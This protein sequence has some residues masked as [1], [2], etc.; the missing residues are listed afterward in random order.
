[1]K[2]RVSRIEVAE[3]AGVSTTT[4]SYVLNGR[5][6]MGIPEVTRDRVLRAASD[7]GY[8]PN[9]AA[10]SLRTGRS[11]L[12]ALW[13]SVLGPAYY[14]QIVSQV[15]E[16]LRAQ[17]YEM[18]VTDT[19]PHPD[20]QAHLDRLSQ[21]P[22]D[23]I[24]AFDSARYVDHYRA[25]HGSHT[26]IVAMGVDLPTGVDTV[27]LDLRCGAEAAMEHLC[28]HGRQRVA[29]VSDSIGIAGLEPRM[30]AYTES[31]RASH[32]DPE[33]II[34][35]RRTRRSAYEAM[36]AHIRAQGCPQAIFCYN[37]DLAMGVQRAV[38]DAGYRIP[39]DVAIVGHDGTEET[40]FTS[41][42]LSTVLLPTERMCATAWELLRLRIEDPSR[43][44]ERIQLSTELIIRESSADP[45]PLDDPSTAPVATRPADATAVPQRRGR[46]A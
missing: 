39:Q 26:P 42:R 34:V 11:N 8:V 20:W 36:V 31:V 21:W 32:K 15:Q 7:L 28:R 12:V 37:D 27:G 18:L 17:G 22:V 2:Q 6:D 9:R 4:V 35:P 10:Q 3:R 43:Q 45:R 23:G 29:F 40:D 19:A 5:T 14:A 16:L 13:M 30:I 38:L 44:P 33:I 25:R 46:K 24:L 1:M 41:P